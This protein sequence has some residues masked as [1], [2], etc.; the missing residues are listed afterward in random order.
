MHEIFKFY[1]D[2]RDPYE[3]KYSWI[4]NQYPFP[5]FSGLNADYA[6]KKW[7]MSY[8][9]ILFLRQYTITPYLITMRP[10]DFPPIPSTQGEIKQWI[11]GIDFFKKLVNDHLKNNELLKT[12]NLDFI[13][14]DWCTENQKLYPC[15]ASGGC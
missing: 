9:A 2:V 10:L 8:M 13:T 3:R 15:L 6:I 1:F 11:D 4:S 14:P 12:L 7:I 5:E